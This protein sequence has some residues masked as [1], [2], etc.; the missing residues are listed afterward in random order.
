MDKTIKGTSRRPPALPLGPFELHARIARGGMGEVW[1]GIHI[2]QQ[3]PVAIKVITA[4]RARRASTQEA[5]RNEVRAIA[6]L[7]HPGV[8]MVFDHGVIPEE[9]E[10]LSQGVLVKGSPYLVMEMASRGS[11]GRL[12]EPL[13]WRELRLVLLGLLQ[14]LAHAHARGII[15]RDM[16]PGNVLMAGP[17]DI[18]P[19]LKLT[20]FGIA[21][22][23]DSHTR[24]DS[25]DLTM[26]TPM[27]MAPEQ[28]RGLWRDYGPWT[29]LYA[30]G[31][32]TFKLA[33]GRYPFKAKNFADLC[34]M[35]LE[36]E[37][38]PLQTPHAMPE[39][40]EE[41]MRCLLEKSPEM[42]F[43]HAADALYALEGLEGDHGEPQGL[44]LDGQEEISETLADVAATV[45]FGQSAELA[46]A[47]PRP[48]AAT[49]PGASH[50]AP[51][52]PESW[53]RAEEM[54][55]V[56]LLGVGLGVYGVRTFPMMGRRAQRT[57]LWDQ[58]REVH[59]LQ[60]AKATVVTGAAGVGKSR[61]VEWIC[62]RAHEVGAA[63]IL[64][65]TH[66]PIAGP[67]FGL[68]G[69]LASQTR[70]LGLSHAEAR[71]RCKRLL[72]QMGVTDAYE[73]A[74]LA[75][76]MIPADDDSLDP[77]MARIH[78]SRARERHALILRHL[79]R[80]ARR[81]PL[82]VW[83]DDVQWAVNS[84]DFVS[85]VLDQQEHHP[86][87]IYFVLTAR[88]EALV[89][90]QLAAWNLK[91][92]LGRP[93]THQM[94]LGP[95]PPEEHGRLIEELLVLQGDLAAQV[96]ARSAGNP[97]FAIHLVGDWV[98][99][100]VLEVGPGG[101]VLRPGEQA[102]LP[103]DLYGVWGA[104]VRR[105][106]EG[107]PPDA[108][109]ALELASVLGLEVN[110]QEWQ[111][112]CQ[113]A[114]LHLPDGILDRLLATRLAQLK[115]DGWSFVHGMLR[116]SLERSA[117]EA[118]RT[119]ALHAACAD[120]LTELHSEGAH[121]VPERRARH[122]LGARLLAPAVDALLAAASERLKEQDVRMAQSL[123][124]RRADVLKELEATDDDLRWGQGW[125]AASKGLVYQDRF[126]EAQA[127]ARQAEQAARRYRWSMLPEALR[128][129]GTIARRRGDFDA[130][131]DHYRQA[132]GPFEDQ[133]DIQGLAY[134]LHGLAEVVQRRGDSDLA[135]DLTQK[136][137]KFFKQI[138][139]DVGVA[140]SLKMLGQNAHGRGDMDRCQELFE[141]ALTIYERIGHKFGMASSANVLADVARHRGDL[142]GAERGYRLALSHFRSVG[143]RGLIPQLN[144]GLT[145]LARDDRAA[146][147]TLETVLKAFEKQGSSGFLVYIHAALMATAPREHDWAGWDHHYNR[148][149]EL[150]AKH[151]LYDRDIA[152][153]A[154]L[155]G[156]KA[157]GAME[158]VR[159]GKAYELA[160]E[161]YKGL[162]DT[163][164]VIEVSASWA[165]I[166]V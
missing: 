63:T 57:A 108:Q 154:H 117:L 43:Q 50:E 101:F 41:W 77:G 36:V 114:G 107:Q 48:T 34:R 1:R 68:P 76:V 66:S 139:D 52:I 46:S 141:Q 20:D 92:L 93:R 80:L 83:L 72:K 161:Q 100:G 75:E 44:A 73:S 121:G 19:G 138:H 149:M 135:Q 95:L 81:R 150:L 94:P 79:E 23:V 71:I 152:W 103:D 13:R 143:G 147:S 64:K 69:M 35:H 12:K 90:Q 99:R 87:P 158:R 22:V 29:D 74:A 129:L 131:A 16:K 7:D 110:R 124:G 30:V 98:Q 134:S 153:C 86:S 32:M 21:H 159:A 40:L 49:A 9:T 126:D 61:L 56:M 109:K 25:R 151:T 120:M 26:G 132:L 24:A 51:T 55:N 65:A 38:P 39:G 70:C 10:R 82:I 145:L 111:V 58:L 142:E 18:R 17:D 42:R 89:E 128:A 148:T 115:V 53:E 84:L 137:L 146:R 3:V 136:A 125:L 6:G 8:V 166:T 4:A 140:M 156:D 113:K 88:D 160:M 104:R 122:L 119:R 47:M 116:E 106:L 54:P 85:Y 102:V 133:G 162:E 91:E 118:G 163:D 96:E 31:C 60:Q 155:A 123:L 67:S 45:V 15:H 97:Q 105:L 59:L 112:A 157:A 14:A 144:L 28:L 2:K 27:Y 78:F 37:P 165:D 33:T 62:E 130:A 11:L 164:K 127:L 5:F